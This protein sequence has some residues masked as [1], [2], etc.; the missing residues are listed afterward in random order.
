MFYHHKF[1]LA[2]LDFHLHYS[3]FAFC[4][5]I[6]DEERSYVEALDGISSTLIGPEG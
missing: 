4:P 3:E 1:K 5:P 2:S 6:E